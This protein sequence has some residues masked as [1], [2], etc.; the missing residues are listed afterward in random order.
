MFLQP[1]QSSMILSLNFPLGNFSHS[2]R[3]HLYPVPCSLALMVYIRK[4]W[5]AGEHVPPIFAFPIAF[6]M[7]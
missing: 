6:S 2:T 5:G 7:V 1:V 3:L 4:L